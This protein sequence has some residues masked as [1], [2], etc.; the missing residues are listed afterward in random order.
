MFHLAQDPRN[1]YT[2]GVGEHNP[3]GLSALGARLVHRL[4]ELGVLVVVSHTS[5]VGIWDVLELVKGPIIAS[6]SNARSVYDNKR[7]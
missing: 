7:N 1:I 6:H 3:G 4:T 5:D 2:D